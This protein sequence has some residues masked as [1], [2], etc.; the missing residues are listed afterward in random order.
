MQ[1]WDT[2]GE[3][4]ALGILGGEDDDVAVSAEDDV[5]EEGVQDTARST[6]AMLHSGRPLNEDD[7][8]S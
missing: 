7:I 2:Q 6:L 5:D 8:V 3:N 1:H 4:V